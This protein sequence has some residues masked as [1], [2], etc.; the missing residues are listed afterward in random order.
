MVK[1]KLGDTGMVAS[2]LL[3]ELPLTIKQLKNGG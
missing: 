3:P 1:E 2:D